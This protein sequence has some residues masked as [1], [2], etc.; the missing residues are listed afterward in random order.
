MGISEIWNGQGKSKQCVT[1]EHCVATDCGS[2]PGDPL[3]PKRSA[4]HC[5][6][7]SHQRDTAEHLPH[8]GQHR[9]ASPE[10]RRNCVLKSLCG[11]Q[12]EDCQVSLLLVAP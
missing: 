4:G 1:Q 8:T 12:G 7:Q 6:L 3:D 11:V 10:L 5:G 9:S 2:C